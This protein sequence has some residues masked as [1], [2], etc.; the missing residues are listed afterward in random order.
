M[1]WLDLEISVL[2]PKRA[3][4]DQ[5][6]FWSL[7]MVVQFLGFRS[8]VLKPLLWDATPQLPL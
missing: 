7:A 4:M 1:L 6:N 2:Y 8:V 3:K 5:V